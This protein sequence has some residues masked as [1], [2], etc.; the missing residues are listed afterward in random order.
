MMRAVRTSPADGAF[1]H[2]AEIEVLRPIGSRTYAT[3]KMGGTPLIAEL[4]AHDVT[5]I[6][7][8]VPIDINLK[9]AAIFDALTERAL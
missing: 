3:F 6:G 4:L 7:D 1:R 9:R 2:E 5:H 8:R